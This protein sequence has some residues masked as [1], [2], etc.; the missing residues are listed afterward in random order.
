MTAL[1]MTDDVSVCVLVSGVQQHYSPLHCHPLPLWA[2]A[3]VAVAACCA[4]CWPG[5]STPSFPH[6]SNGVTWPAFASVMAV[7]T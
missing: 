1:K 2:V 6:N 3:C 7:Q 5:R 4:R